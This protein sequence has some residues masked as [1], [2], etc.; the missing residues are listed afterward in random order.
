MAQREPRTDLV[1]QQ[2]AV[3]CGMHRHQPSRS[4]DQCS[5][6]KIGIQMTVHEP[7]RD[8]QN[9]DSATNGRHV[10]PMGPDAHITVLYLCVKGY[11]SF[12]PTQLGLISEATLRAIEGVVARYKAREASAANGWQTGLSDKIQ[13]NEQEH[14]WQMVENGLV[15]TFRADLDR[16]LRPQ[17]QWA[18]TDGRGRAVMRNVH[19]TGRFP[20]GSKR[21]GLVR[22]RL[23]NL[24]A[25]LAPI[26]A[27]L[28]LHWLLLQ[29]DF[30]F[31]HGATEATATTAANRIAEAEFFVASGADAQR[32]QGVGPKMGALVDAAL[33]ELRERGGRASLPSPPTT[34]G[35]RLGKRKAPD[36][37]P[38]APSAPAGRPGGPSWQVKLGGSF[39]PYAERSVHEALEA[40][41]TGGEDKVEVMVRGTVYVVDLRATPMR[42]AQKAEPAKTREVRRVAPSSSSG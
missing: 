1:L 37:A 2:G 3:L 35:Q 18:S 36:A 22:F 8:Y 25:H 5:Y 6:R 32:L 34:G 29:H 28:P 11:P 39:Q 12:A 40:A 4:V 14:G 38:A 10:T 23:V 9:H 7:G 27:N 21:G 41:L 20:E 33:A 13:W 42:Q 16:V 30:C 15:H 31:K 24:Q 17:H 19:C 26:A